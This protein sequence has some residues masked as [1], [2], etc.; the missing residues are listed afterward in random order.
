MTSR[1]YSNIASRFSGLLPIVLDV[2]TG[3]ANHNTDAL[4][5]VAATIIVMDKDGMLVPDTSFACHVEAFDG[6]NIEPRALEIN[7]IIPDH[8]FRY[9]KPEKE[10]LTELFE[11]ARAAVKANRC[12]RAVLVG[13]NAHFDLSFI[14]A[15]MKRCELKGPFH[16]FTCFDTAT[17]GGLAYGETVLAKALKVAKIPYDED[18]AH[19]AIYDV[20]CTV[21]LFCKIVN[22]F[23]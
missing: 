18:E 23:E 7:K 14:M 5:E 19:S 3:G 12:R 21:K 4:L 1:K 22:E 10:A 2:E 15:A 20:D 9:A 6:A 11:W 17:L 16:S 13:H 8:P